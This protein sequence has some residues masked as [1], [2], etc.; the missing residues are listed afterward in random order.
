MQAPTLE[1]VRTPRPYS[2]FHIFFLTGTPC[3]EEQF[4]RSF[5]EKRTWE[6]ISY[7]FFLS[8]ETFQDQKGPLTL[9]WSRSW[10]RNP[11]GRG[12]VDVIFTSCSVF[13]LW[14]RC[15]PDPSPNPVA[16]W[17]TS[18]KHH[19]MFCWTLSCFPSPP[20]TSKE[21]PAILF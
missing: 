11:Q 2:R 18:T 17:H 3:L 12:F 8:F 4:L 16:R 14:R 1:R 20:H 21:L 13:Q 15:H 7:F 6:A 5:L 10:V 19:F 9:F